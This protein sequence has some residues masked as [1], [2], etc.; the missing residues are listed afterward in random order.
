MVV[1]GYIVIEILNRYL[2]VSVGIKHPHP[3]MYCV[4]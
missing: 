1:V 2:S 3:Q 4:K